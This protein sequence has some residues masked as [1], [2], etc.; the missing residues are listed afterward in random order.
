LL[1]LKAKKS[2]TKRLWQDGLKQLS[3]EKSEFLLIGNQGDIMANRGITFIKL[4]PLLFLCPVVCFAIEIPDGPYF[5]QQPPGLQAEVFAPG[6]ISLNNRY[7]YGFD[8]STDARQF[9]FTITNSGWDYFEVLYTYIDED[10]HWV[11]PHTPPFC[12]T[13][14]Q[15]MYPCF[16]SDG[17]KVFVVAPL[18]QGPPWNSDIFVS[19]RTADGWSTPV[20]LGE[21]INS[22]GMEYR[23][24]ITDN[25]T[26]YVLSNRA[27]NGG[28][29]YRS[30]LM[31]S[32]YS[33]IEKVG[34]PISTEHPEGSPFIAP[35]ESYIIFE[36]GRPGG[37]GQ[38][39][40][41]ISF[42]REDGSWDPAVN[43][44]PQV[45]T[46]GIE[47]SGFITD[48]GKYFFFCSRVAYV[49]NIQTDIYWM[50]SRAVLPD[51]NGPVQNLAT[52]QRFAS[53]QCAVNYAE[54]GD[55]I[56]INPGMYRESINLAGKTVVLQS[57]DP[58]DSFYIGGTIIQG[59]TDGPVVSL[60]E[61]SDNCTIAGL[62][63]RAGS[64]GI[65]SSAANTTIRNCRIM[66]NVTNGLEL[67]QGSSPHLQHCL[68]TGNGQ[69]GVTML[70]GTS[71]KVCKPVIEN[72]IIIQNGSEDI[73]GGQ[74]VT[75]DSIV[76]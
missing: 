59:Y 5:G 29:I 8:F 51:P 26:L 1:C 55:I 18:Y 36:S 24:S 30:P 35:D 39:D 65:K 19:K 60:K 48:D 14:V 46:D 17:Q 76:E 25:Q 32:E 47:D 3:N 75:I 70:A 27:G 40:L 45:N 54:E 69:T 56:V 74:P 68:I 37:F 49:T 41:Y 2:E 71:R 57:V 22:S 10:G 64:I 50:D 15:S 34:F 58:N 44:G 53:V 11:E 52:G 72:C 16:S 62:T 4:I 28:D 7:E 66:D 33:V 38:N 42:R 63:I 67:S 13:L 73:V 61:N 9:A 21:P 20:N 31:D 12:E 6:I 43:L 23:P